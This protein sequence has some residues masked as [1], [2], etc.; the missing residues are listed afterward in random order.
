MIDF[1]YVKVLTS[2][3]KFIKKKIKNLRMT[4]KG[5]NKENLTGDKPVFMLVEYYDFFVTQKNKKVAAKNLGEK[6]ALLNSYFFEYLKGYNIPCAFVKKAEHKSLQLLNT[7]DFRFRVKILNAADGRTAKVFSIK[8]GSSL[9]LPI[10][11]YHFGDSKESVI[12]ES[13]IISFNLC[14]YEEL[15]MINRLCSK[16]NAIVKSFFERRNISLLELTCR[17]GKFDGKIYLIG[18]FSPVSIKVL[19]HKKV[20]KLPDPYKIETAAQMNKYSDYLLKLTSG[21]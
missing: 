12:T 6:T 20:E 4:T 16:I 10:L 9:E 8:H 19:D 18:D 14:S 11:E 3:P 13:H 5:N 1:I 2:A 17:F 15:K 21:D 7:S